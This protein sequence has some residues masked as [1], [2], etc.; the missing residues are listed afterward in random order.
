MDALPTQ[1]HAIAAPSD[2]IVRCTPLL[3]AA[4]Q[5]LDVAC[6]RHPLPLTQPQPGSTRNQANPA[7]SHVQHS[8]FLRRTN[9]QSQA[10]GRS[11]AH[12]RP[13]WWCHQNPTASFFRRE[14]ARARQLPLLISQTLPPA[15]GV[16]AAAPPDS[17]FTPAAAQHAARRP[18]PP[19]SS[20]SLSNARALVRP[21]T[22]AHHNMP[23]H[24]GQAARSELLGQRPTPTTQISP[25]L[26]SRT[27]PTSTAH[28]DPKLK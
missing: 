15:P 21:A 28:P 14:R 5:V 10:P 25:R 20:A 11:P 3:P 26:G 13:R 22:C 23:D 6:N 7:C 16:A 8:R 18:P 2:W 24:R 12:F 1:A 17:F 19:A 27:P 9:S 4:A